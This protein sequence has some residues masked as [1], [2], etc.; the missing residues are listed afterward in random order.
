MM[1]ASSVLVG[2]GC[3][4]MALPPVSRASTWGLDGSGVWN[5]A[6][7][8]SGPVPNAV[9][10][11]AVFG[12]GPGGTAL[13]RAVALQSAAV[14]VGALEFDSAAG[15]AYDLV[16]GTIALQGSFGG[17]G[18]QVK[19]TTAADQTIRASLVVQ[20]GQSLQIIQ[21]AAGR[22]LSLGGS[23]SGTSGS[24][25]LINGAGT[26]EVG[27]AVGSGITSL[28]RTSGSGTLILASANTYDGPTLI[29]A[30]TLRMAPGGSTG[31]GPTTVSGSGTRLTG[32]G[33]I[34]A[35]L[36]MEPGSAVFGASGS[37]EAE[38]LTIAGNAALSAGTTL[39]VEILSAAAYD[40]LVVTAG[41]GPGTE[42]NGAILDL[43]FAAPPNAG[44]SFKIIDMQGTGFL[45]AANSLRLP[46]S[47]VLF[48]DDTFT[49]G[50]TTMRISYDVNPGGG[51]ILTVA[52]QPAIVIDVPSGTQTQSQA[53]YP[54]IGVA[55]S[56]TKTGA[57]TLIFDAANSYTGP[58]IVA[59]G[60]LRAADAASLAQTAVTVSTG[61][62]LAVDA[63]VALKAA[64]VIVAGGTLSAGSLAVDASQGIASLVI[65]GGG[66]AGSPGVRI[67][68]AGTMS[69][70]DDARVT[71]VLGGLA[72][73][74]AGSDA[75]LLDLGGGEVSVAAGGIPETDLRA[76]LLAGRAGGAWN[77]STGITSSTAAAAGG[78]RAVGYVIGADGSARVSFAAPGDTDL[79]GKVDI[80]DLVNIDSSGSYG[81]GQP[82]IWAVGDFNYD[83][84]TNVFDLV[85][86][87][88]A[89]AYG[90]G[91]Y[92]PPPPSGSAAGMAAVPEASGVT[93][94]LAGFSWLGCGRR[95]AVRSRVPEAR[96][97]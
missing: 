20:G 26:V 9:G 19:P 13:A 36:L 31:L 67:S 80:F 40:R 24:Q 22:T 35:G 66:I 71:V 68:S 28:N 42:L 14:T 11:L 32:E 78:T 53:G 56:V 45:E 46:D 34:N 70:A 72:V 62:T 97:T 95:R 33:T 30:G 21:D 8:W 73:V 83:G 52:G 27:G 75:G 89:G 47:T 57:G 5:D 91:D 3:V 86:I 17:A 4:L 64:A 79:D 51:V 59:A 87:N 85:A 25:L 38:T 76:D 23:I 50:G 39:T 54:A 18:I 1:R 55:E 6:G 74:E 84:V 48:N 37:G 10:A 93:L 65:R 12:D 96:Q 15:A 81:T 7:N 88:T 94:L 82:S 43:S 77:G 60:T 44:G 92:F 69:L 16:D 90:Q 61:A 2:M 63:G 29:D 58:T 49:V 41:S